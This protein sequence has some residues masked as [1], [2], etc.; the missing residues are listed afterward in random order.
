M[1]Y[2][3]RQFL[4]QASGAAIA[5]GI[6]VATAEAEEKKSVASELPIVDTH[7]HLWDL[8]KLRL[9]WLKGS[10]SLNRSY[11]MKDYLEAIQGLG[12]VKSVYMEVNV[13]FD[14]QVAEAEYVLDIIRAGDAPTCA[15]VIG[16]RPGDEGFRRYI[17]RFKGN[18]HI[19]GVRQILPGQPA[20]KATFLQKPFLDGIRLLGELGMSF[21]LC[22][23]ADALAAGAAL[24]DRCPDTRFILDHCGNADPKWFL[25]DAGEEPRRLAENWRRDIARL[26]E[27]KN[28]VCKISGIV[29]RVPT[30]WTPS[31]LAPI[32]DHCLDSFGPDRAIF[33][34]DW[35]VCTRGA[36]LR[37]WVEALREVI[38]DRPLAD[39]RKLLAENAIRLYGLNRLPG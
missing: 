9:S 39:Q 11:V 20:D 8:S 38:A 33:A 37:R 14:Q 15:A 30:P 26:A 17:T 5:A 22:M 12:I 2:D 27:R 28:V 32:I 21:D 19:K 1:Q 7:Q 3:R 24:V 10:D 23:P 35:P 36:S 29:A 31:M 4:V 16:G 18:P 34:S 6:T 25:K 13:D